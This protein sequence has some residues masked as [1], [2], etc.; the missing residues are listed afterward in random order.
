M[1]LAIALTLLCLAGCTTPTPSRGNEPTYS[2]NGNG[3]YTERA[4]RECAYLAVGE[5]R[6]DPT[7]DADLLFTVCLHEV[8]VR[9]I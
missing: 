2:G 6:K 5:F 3:N 1:K 8:G 9:S 7:I 4:M